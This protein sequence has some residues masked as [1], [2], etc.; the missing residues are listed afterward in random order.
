MHFSLLYR[1]PPAGSPLRAYLL[2]PQ[3]GNG[4]A[5]SEARINHAPRGRL[6]LP[7]S[8]L[9]CFDLAANEDLQLQADLETRA[10]FSSKAPVEVTSLLRSLSHAAR[11]RL[12]KEGS[13]IGWLSQNSSLAL[14]LALRREA[15]SLGRR[16]TVLLGHLALREAT[17]HAWVRLYLPEGDFEF[18]PW[19]FLRLQDEPA[20]WLSWGL[21]PAADDYLSGHEGRR[22]CWGEVPLPAHGMPCI[23]SDETTPAQELLP[24]P[25]IDLAA[26]GFVFPEG[27]EI[28]LQAQG[29]ENAYNMALAALRA[30][31][32]V[33]FALIALGLLSPAGWRLLL[34]LPYAAVL[35]WGQGR[36][37]LRLWSLPNGWRSALEASL[38]HA[39]LVTVL[40]GK[41]TVL[42][43]TLFVIYWA[44]N[45][46]EPWW[47]KLR[48]KEPS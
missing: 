1:R 19:F 14:A 25:E 28:T 33:V 9:A 35:A 47:R 10:T 18:D 31:A 48:S 11:E 37:W 15:E 23:G 38:F 41:D 40:V 32:F 13:V 46:L 27:Y 21:S 8:V 12:Q 45:R 26:Q 20:F 34:Y 7:A 6:V 39:A 5:L 43:Q 44:Y 29:A 3:D 24:W 22:L 2:L 42:P 30:L 4:Q 36:A 16:A 17:P